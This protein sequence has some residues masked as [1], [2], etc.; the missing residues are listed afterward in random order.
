[1]PVYVQFEN[2]YVL[3]DPDMRHVRRLGPFPFVQLTYADLRVGPGGEE[4][5]YYDR[6]LDFWFLNDDVTTA[7]SDV[8]IATED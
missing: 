5:A 1:M 7:Y 3:V 2:G 4:V 6:E 8:I